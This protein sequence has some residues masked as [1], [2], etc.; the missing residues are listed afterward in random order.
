MFEIKKPTT[1]PLY[2]NT[3]RGNYYWHTETVKAI[4]QAEKYLFESERK[5]PVLSE[6]IKR[7]NNEDVEVIKPKV[8]LVI[9]SSEQLDKNNMKEDFRILRE[10]LKNV[11]I[12]LYDELYE[13]FKYLK[14]GLSELNT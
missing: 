2:K 6:D 7:E 13:R 5:E 9:G 8:F 4:T 3:D 14:K 10:S 11:N 12:I 1:P